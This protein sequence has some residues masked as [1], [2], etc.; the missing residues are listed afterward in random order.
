MSTTAYLAYRFSSLPG[1][2]IGALSLSA[3]VVLEAW[4]VRLMTTGLVRTV[5]ERSRA[6]DRDAD[7]RLGALTRFYTPLALTSLLALASQPT[8]TFFLGQS[9]GALESLAVLPVVHGLTFVFRSLGLSFLEV[10]IALLGPSRQHFRTILTFAVGL[11]LAGAASLSLIAFTP[12]A[13]VWFHDIT[14]LS[15]ELT[16][17]AIMP[18]RI[19]AVL[20]ALSVLLAL[21][22]GVLI[23]ARRNTPITW[24]TLI[25][26]AGIVVVMVAGIHLLD[27]VGAVAAAV[28]ITC[29]RVASTAWLIPTCLDVL[30]RSP[31]VTAQTISPG[32]SDAT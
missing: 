19:L 9:R 12:L 15:E 8:V 24:A 16:E 14:G 7:L 17:F 27:F 29:A 2:F 4:A 22:R 6:P 18:T 32:S 26:L 3:G 30:R 1:T 31:P 11:G 10:V 21:E 28:A 20:P 23:H 5:L 13:F 25:E